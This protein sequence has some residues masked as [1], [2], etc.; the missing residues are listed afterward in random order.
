MHESACLTGGGCH[1]S[2]HTRLDAYSASKG[3]IRFTGHI[4][5]SCCPRDVWQYFHLRSHSICSM[6]PSSPRAHLRTMAEKPHRS[7]FEILRTVLYGLFAWHVG[8]GGY[9]SGPAHEEVIMPSRVEMHVLCMTSLGVQTWVY[10]I[11]RWPK[12]DNTTYIGRTECCD[13]RKAQWRQAIHCGVLSVVLWYGANVVIR[14]KLMFIKKPSV[15][16]L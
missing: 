3:V 12:D 2:N 13:G 4:R 1:P 10:R 16:G 6:M 15:A 14:S 11:E 8:A 5:I 9:M 7:I